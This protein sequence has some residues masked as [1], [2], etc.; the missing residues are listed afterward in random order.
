[1]REGGVAYQ[2]NFLIYELSS[3]FEISW[4]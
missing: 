3:P 4:N 2:L 1:M